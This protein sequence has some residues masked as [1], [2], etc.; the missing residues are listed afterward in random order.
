[1]HEV[2]AHQGAVAAAQSNPRK[3]MTGS[4]AELGQKFFWVELLQQKQRRNG[5]AAKERLG[6]KP[7]RLHKLLL[8]FETRF[9]IQN[10]KI[11]IFLNQI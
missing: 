2:V 1:V 11:Q 3:E 5:W 8:D 10:S 7:R 9:W 6:R 4:W